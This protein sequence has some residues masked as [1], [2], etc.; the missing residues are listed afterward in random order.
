MKKMIQFVVACIYDLR[1][2][3]KHFQVMNMK[4]TTQ[5]RKPA[6]MGGDKDAN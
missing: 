6:K 5:K 3:L 1:K 2:T 4:K